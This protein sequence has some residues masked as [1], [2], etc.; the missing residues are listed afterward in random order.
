MMEPYEY[1]RDGKFFTGAVLLIIGVLLLL[2][3]LNVLEFRP[4]LSHWWP[5]ILVIIGIKH[6]VL[7]RGSRGLA[8]GIFWI[9]T[10]GLF[11]ASTL[12][13]INVAITNILW[14]LMLIWFGVLIALG[15][16]LC[17]KNSMRN[18]SQM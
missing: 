13:F 8:G 2:G 16:G 4:I 17:G 15:P 18:G 3:N 11:L 7:M 9:G 5:L 1:R 12:G 14:P 10:G 6:L